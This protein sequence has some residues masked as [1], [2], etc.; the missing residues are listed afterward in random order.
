MGF[1]NENNPEN[2]AKAY[3]IASKLDEMVVDID[4]AVLEKAVRYMG[5]NTRESLK[6]AISIAESKENTPKVA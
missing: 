5:A 3:E 4:M 6:N 2:E 1:E